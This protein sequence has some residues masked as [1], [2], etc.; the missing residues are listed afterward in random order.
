MKRD[1]TDIARGKEEGLWRKEK[2][3]KS[4]ERT[5]VHSW[6]LPGMPL[7]KAQFKMSSTN[8]CLQRILGGRLTKMSII[9]IMPNAGKWVDRHQH[10]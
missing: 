3:K 2:K 6:S 9:Y 10:Y 8:T 7:F 4:N 1:C 5:T